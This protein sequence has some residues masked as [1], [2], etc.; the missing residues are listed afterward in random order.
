MK[1]R[2]KLENKHQKQTVILRLRIESLWK[3]LEKIQLD[4][5]TEVK[6][7]F[8]DNEYLFYVKV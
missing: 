5:V 1:K 3:Y 4:K 2:L 8:I 6:D 7:Y